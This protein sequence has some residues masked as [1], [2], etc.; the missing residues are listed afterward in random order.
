MV[1]V[2][3][4]EMSPN[5]VTEPGANA[6]LAAGASTLKEALIVVPVMPRLVIVSCPQADPLRLRLTAPEPI[7]MTPPE[8]AALKVIP[9]AGQAA[10]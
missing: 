4:A 9:P 6:T 1:V 7:L 10:G 3:G 8:K 2:S 5:S